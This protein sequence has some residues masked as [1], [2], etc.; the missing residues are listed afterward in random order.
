MSHLLASDLVLALLGTTGDAFVST[1]D[2][3]SAVGGGGGGSNSEKKAWA[4]SIASPYMSSFA[5]SNDVHLASMPERQ[6]MN[7]LVKLGFHFAELSSFAETCDA[8]T[9]DA[10]VDP[11]VRALCAGIEEVLQEYTDD[12]LDVEA[13]FADNIVAH[14]ASSVSLAGAQARLARYGTVLP[15]LHRLAARYA[16]AT[17][18]AAQHAGDDDDE[19][20]R[21]PAASQLLMELHEAS[22]TAAPPWKDVASRLLWH[23][24]QVFLRQTYAWVAH[25]E[26]LGGAFFVAPSDGS[27]KSLELLD[28]SA[29]ASARATAE[30]HSGFDLKASLVPPF[31]STRA[32]SAV[33]FAGRAIRVLRHQQRVNVAQGRRV[34]DGDGDGDA[35]EVAQSAASHVRRWAGHTGSFPTLDFERAATQ[36]Q[37]AAAKALHQTVVVNS[38]LPQHLR[39]CRD[40]FLLA[41]GHL[42]QSFLAEAD[43]LLSLPPRGRSASEASLRAAWDAAMASAHGSLTP[44]PLARLFSLTLA[45]GSE[46]EARAKERSSAKGMSRIR[47]PSYDGWD[48]VGMSYEPPWPI[49]LMLTPPVVRTYGTMFQF[50]LRMRR[51]SREL[52]KC[53]AA[54][55]RLDVVGGNFVTSFDTGRPSSSSG[56]AV[57]H[58]VLQLRHALSHVVTNL[59]V[60]VMVDVVEPSFRRM[61]ASLEAPDADYINVERLH[62]RM[63]AD[64]A[65]QSFLDV[66]AIVAVYEEVLSLERRLSAIIFTRAGGPSSLAQSPGASR[67]RSSGLDASAVNS[68]QADFHDTVKKLLTF[69][70]GGKLLGGARAP[71]LRRFLTRLDYN[72]FFGVGIGSTTAA[73]GSSSKEEEE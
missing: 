51:C 70:Q 57:L 2:D 22:C 20:E 48:G 52:D 60:Y 62:T 14:D 56:G 46:L 33:S 16:D 61:L 31:V 40:L 49:G 68:L 19:D 15:A 47:A 1:A 66:P 26:L 7:T 73:G 12:V 9:N 27:A 58:Q 69:L 35:G 3:T 54:L 32:A 50:L 37:S 65:A 63:L 30:W 59:L 71:S 13:D 8:A 36:L 25:G 39:L 10:P 41:D 53:W 29:G 67:A 28:A 45:R 5:L 24:T 64:L 43:S 4:M 21:L 23:L 55:R 6:Q 42:F 11:Y 38:R 17:T 34:G 18:T 72:G 44:H